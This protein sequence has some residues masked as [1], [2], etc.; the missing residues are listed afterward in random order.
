MIHLQNDKEKPRRE[1]ISDFFA[2]KLLKFHFK[3]GIL[4]IDDH[5]HV[6]FSPN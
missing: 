2:W 5:N 3:R 4:P 1:K 6:I